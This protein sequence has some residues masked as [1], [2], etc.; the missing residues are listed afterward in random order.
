V[1]DICAGLG[2][3]KRRTESAFLCLQAAEDSIILRY[4]K[5]SAR[6]SRDIALH[7]RENT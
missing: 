7:A 4:K 3:I 6:G 2:R 5:A 1:L